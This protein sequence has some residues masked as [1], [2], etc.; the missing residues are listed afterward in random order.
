MQCGENKV[1]GF[2]GSKSD[3]DTFRVTHLAYHNNIGVVTENRSQ[4][5]V[6]TEGI[7]AQFTL[8]DDGTFVGM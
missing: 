8:S 3:T 4:S 5:I 1:T 2:S 6:K 7:S